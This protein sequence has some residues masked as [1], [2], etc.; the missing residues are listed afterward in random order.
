M[1]IEYFGAGILYDNLWMRISLMFDYYGFA[2][3]TFPLFFNSNCFALQDVHKANLPRH[4]RENWRPVRVPVEQFHS[5]FNFLTVLNFNS[6]TI[7][8][9]EPVEF[10]LLCVKNSYFTI[11]FEGDCLQSRVVL[12]E[13]NHINVTILNLA[14]LCG[15]LLAF[16]NGS[17][18][19]A[20]GVESTQR[21]LCA[22][23]TY[24]LCSNNANCRTFFDKA[25]G[26]QVPAITLC[27]NTKGTITG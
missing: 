26:T 22:G 19:D 23:F 12:F 11:A 5:S 15:C 1:D 20:A 3:L 24:R 16:K 7:G 25:T 13:G 4:F 14:C 8:H 6:G 9:F 18:G 10:P 27:T 21:Q 2:D 17:S